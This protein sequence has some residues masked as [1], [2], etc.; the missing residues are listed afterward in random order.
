MRLT[1]P[2]KNRLQKSAQAAADLVLAAGGDG[3]I[4]KVAFRLIDSAFR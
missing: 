3:T 4:A 1:N 2:R